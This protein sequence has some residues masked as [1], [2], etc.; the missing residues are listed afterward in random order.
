[1]GKAKNNLHLRCYL[2][3]H[4]VVQL[5]SARMTVCDYALYICKA[6]RKLNFVLCKNKDKLKK[7]RFLKICNCS[8]CK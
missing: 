5:L 7:N 3:L 6:A 4:I 8:A 2:L 1:M